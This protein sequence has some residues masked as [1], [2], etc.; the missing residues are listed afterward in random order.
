MKLTV[1]LTNM[2]DP[3]S[4]DLSLHLPDHHALSDPLFLPLF[5]L[6]LLFFF[7]PRFRI[8]ILGGDLRERRRRSEAGGG[9]KPRRSEAAADRDGC[10]ARRRELPPA[11]L[12]RRRGEVRRRSR[13]AGRLA[14][15]VQLFFFLLMQKV[16]QNVF[17][18]F[19]NF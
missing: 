17:F 5:S 12:G 19:F 1:E 9:A 4:T 2:V 10:G 16:L 8:R 15:A 7:L 6:L 18:N 3:T 14:A 11:T 13:A